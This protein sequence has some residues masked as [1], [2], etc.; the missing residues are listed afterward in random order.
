MYNRILNR[1][2]RY[3]FRILCL[4]CYSTKPWLEFILTLYIS[5]IVVAKMYEIV[6]YFISVKI[7]ENIVGFVWIFLLSGYKM[8]H[9]VSCLRTLSGRRQEKKIQEIFQ[10]VDYTFQLHLFYQKSEEEKELLNGVIFRYYWIFETLWILSTVIYATLVGDFMFVIFIIRYLFAIEGVTAAYLQQLM[11]VEEIEKRLKLLNKCLAKLCEG[12][13]INLKTTSEGNTRCFGIPMTTSDFSDSVPFHHKDFPTSIRTYQLKRI[14][15]MKRIYAQLSAASRISSSLYGLGLFITNILS[16]CDFSEVCY[17]LIVAIT[18]K[19]FALLLVFRAFYSN[20]P[21]VIKFICLCKQC[22]SCSS[23]T[24]DILLKLRSSP[25]K[26][27]LVDDFILQI[28]QNPI[29]FTAYDF[30][31]LNTETLTQVS[32][33]VF[34]LMLFLVQMFYLTNEP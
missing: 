31:E 11:A 2:Y 32:V 10:D 33:I 12:P 34:D 16:I 9:I 28:R 27:L 22:E 13:T 3:Y 26:S 21:A 14:A 30:Y 20:L 1:I 8:A 6:A 19:A 23:V 17:F 4:S 15:T 7:E 25:V 18:D 24:S 5:L 29:K